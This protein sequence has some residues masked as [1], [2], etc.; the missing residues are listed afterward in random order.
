MAVL[1][2][3]SPSSLALNAA[4]AVTVLRPMLTYALCAAL[5]APL[6]AAARRGALAAELSSLRRPVRGSA[7][8]D[9]WESAAGATVQALESASA[10]LRE[11]AYFQANPDVEAVVE[12]EC[13][14]AAALSWAPA[15]H[16]KALRSLSKRLEDG[17]HWV[18]A[19]EAA[20]AAHVTAARA[21]AAEAVAEESPQP[22][23]LPAYFLLKPALA[24]P[25]PLAGEQQRKVG[26]DGLESIDDLGRLVDAAAV[27]TTPLTPRSTPG[28]SCLSTDLPALGPCKGR[29]RARAAPRRLAAAATRPQGLF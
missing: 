4:G 16:C 22:P 3:R 27:I 8:S 12:M 13:A 21:E 20:A 1:V 23:P 25:T 9:G 14:V 24:P 6:G 7:V 5:Y 2:R 26:L 19:A 29:A 28:S 11:L 10:R 15:A 17:Q 18:E